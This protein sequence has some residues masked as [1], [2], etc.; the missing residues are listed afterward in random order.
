MDR[1]R[2]DVI[3][4][5]GSARV[6]AAAQAA[7]AGTGSAIPCRLIVDLLQRLNEIPHCPG[8]IPGELN[9][10]VH[11]QETHRGTRRPH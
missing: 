2:F 4:V 6:T 10:P 1:P 5:K 9:G 11:I 7:Q 8:L 3:A